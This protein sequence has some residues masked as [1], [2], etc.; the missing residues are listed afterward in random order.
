MLQLSG[1]GLLGLVSPREVAA[2]Q[3]VAQATRATPAPRIK[4]LA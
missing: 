2:D 3:A 4:A 1:A